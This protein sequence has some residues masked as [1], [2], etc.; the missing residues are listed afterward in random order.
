M[1]ARPLT[2]GIDASQIA[3]ATASPAEYDDHFLALRDDATLDLHF[4]HGV[5]T[6]TTWEGQAAA[7]LADIVVRGLTRTR[8]RRLAI[9]SGNAKALRALPDGWLRVV[10]QDAPMATKAAWGRLFA[11]LKAEHWPDETDHTLELRAVVEQLLLGPEA[12]AELGEAFL[13]GRALVI[14]RKAL[15][16]GPATAIDATLA[17]LKHDDGLVAFVSVAWMPQV[18]LRLPRGPMYGLSVL[19]PHAGHAVSPRI[20]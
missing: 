11:G 7:A 3:I 2:S 10:P 17:N 6:V 12:A 14:W 15:L 16:A 19:I 5:R 13:E 18:R 20:G 8:L 1:G 9:L 4:V